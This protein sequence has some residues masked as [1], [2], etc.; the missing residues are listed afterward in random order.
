[1]TVPSSGP[2]QC[3]TD[4]SLAKLGASIIASK[5]SAEDYGLIDE[6]EA[7][8]CKH[9]TIQ[10]AWLKGNSTTKYR[11]FRYFGAPEDSVDLHQLLN[12]TSYRRHLKSPHLSATPPPLRRYIKARNDRVR[13]FEVWIPWDNHPD[14]MAKIVKHVVRRYPA[15]GKGAN[16]ALNQAMVARRKEIQA[17]SQAIDRC[18]VVGLTTTRSAP[19]F[20]QGLL[21]DLSIT[22]WQLG[23]VYLLRDIAVRDLETT[24]EQHQGL[25]EVIIFLRTQKL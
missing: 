17:L 10:D 11:L 6:A 9:D 4:Q 23:H 2:N 13:K 18:Y 25:C 15:S 8:E 19:E 12:N 5:S 1:M 14:A 16:R 7:L 24:A 22:P 20:G 21:S 3:G